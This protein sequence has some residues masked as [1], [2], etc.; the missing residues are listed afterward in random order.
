M[1]TVMNPEV[2]DQWVQIIRDLCIIVVG[3][4]MLIYET[5]FTPVPNYLIVGGGLT[6]F[7]VPPALR[8]DQVR[9]RKKGKEGAEPKEREFE[10]KWSHLQ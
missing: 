5:V 9:R 7:G 3:A 1:E 8:I 4:F 10:E 6:L 2:I